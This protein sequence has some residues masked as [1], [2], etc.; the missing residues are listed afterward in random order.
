MPVNHQTVVIDQERSRHFKLVLRLLLDLSVR[1]AQDSDEV[2]KY[3]GD[4]NE[5]DNQSALAT[6]LYL[7]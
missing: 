5:V 1:C 6:C 4:H 3:D 2:N 7:L